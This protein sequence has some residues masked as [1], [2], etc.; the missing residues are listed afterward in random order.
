M[1]RAARHRHAGLGAR[2]GR[3]PR[4]RPGGGRCARRTRHRPGRGRP[5]PDPGRRRRGR[6]RRLA[7]VRDPADDP[8]GAGRLGAAGGGA[9][10]RIRPARAGH[11]VAR[12]RR[13]AR[14]GGAVRRHAGRGAGQP[15]AARRGVPARR[16]PRLRPAAVL[17][18]L[19]GDRRTDG[20][21]RR[22]HAHRRDGA[23]TGLGGGIDAR[24]LGR[25]ARA[26][27]PPTPEEERPRR[28][29]SAPAA[30]SIPGAA[31]G[32]LRRRV[33]VPAGPA[34]PRAM[35][36]RGRRRRA[37]GDRGRAALHR[38]HDLRRGP[39][40]VGGG[41]PAGPGPRAVR[42]A[43]TPPGRRVAGRDRGTAGA[44][45]RV[46]RAVAGGAS[47]TGRAERR[48]RADRLRERDH[49]GTHVRL[50]AGRPGRR[51]PLRAGVRPAAEPVAGAAGGNRAA[52][53]RR[54]AHLRLGNLGGRRLGAVRP[55]RG[56]LLLRRLD[57]RGLPRRPAGAASLGK[58]G[59]DH[60]VRL[61]LVPG[62]AGARRQRRRHPRLARPGRSPGQTRIPTGRTGAGRRH[63]G[64]PGH[65]RDR[66]PARRLRVH[67][68]RGR[69]PLQRRPG[70]RPGQG[71][72][73]HRAAAHPGI[74][75]VRRRRAL[76][77]EGGVPRRRAPFRRRPCRRRPGQLSEP[78]GFTR[79]TSTFTSRLEFDAS[80]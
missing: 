68:H 79:N 73:R 10:P 26:R 72:L 38:R 20:P 17:R 9:V 45:R 65:L 30:A 46:R 57:R 71:Q 53:V 75:T 21:G 28:C 6:E 67:V 52:A 25:R 36:A 7:T 47:R 69:L 11:P 42:V 33:L 18:A 1:A 76:G 44:G 56:G 14:P 64:T 41:R 74:G 15:R 23:A 8:A 63:R 62:C 31:R 37:A 35:A 49:P 54:T 77:A 5:R 32:A 16:P 78:S 51:I 48:L 22:R 58:A 4:C 66:G 50:A 2:P 3:P 13:R 39:R 59:A 80:V 61:L 12:Q 55:G 29:G 40:P 70:P 27:G 24:H 19:D 60:R 43:A 34:L